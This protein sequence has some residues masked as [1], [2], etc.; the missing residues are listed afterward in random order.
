MKK[1]VLIFVL[2]F[3]VFAGVNG[4]TKNKNIIRIIRAHNSPIRSICILKDNLISGG[5]DGYIKIWNIKTGKLI[6]SWKAH[7]SW[8]LDI[9][10][11]HGEIIS[12]SRDS[13]VKVWNLKGK[14]KHKFKVN[15]KW[16]F[17]VAAT[18][19]G[20][21]G[22]AT[23]Y[24][25]GA[26][27]GIIRVWQK[28]GPGRHVNLSPRLIKKFK[29]HTKDINDIKI[30]GA[31]LLASA[32]DDKTVKV[33]DN[34]TL[35]RTLRGHNSIVMSVDMF[36]PM[37]LVSS[38]RDNKVV[39]WEGQGKTVLHG[40]SASVNS[41]KLSK[42][43]KFVVSGSS[44]KTVKI[45]DVKNKKCIRT[46]IGHK[47]RVNNVEF[48]NNGKVIISSGHDGSLIILRSFLR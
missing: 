10:G 6:K 42:D 3:V 23:F 27:D 17:S 32:S 31:T 18:Y 36:S 13:Y 37:F 11:G 39:I 35:M 47:S 20:E 9:A 45:W 30:I 8:V 22:R 15:N 44:D 21:W 12:S 19:V 7:N 33:W 26:R 48:Y 1:R 2:T 25:A 29:A 24:V 38:G 46:L 16:I 41:V 34:F 14:L 43:N 40:H 5:D 28:G 4:I